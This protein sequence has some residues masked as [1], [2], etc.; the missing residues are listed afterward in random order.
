MAFWDYKKSSA[1]TIV[2]DDDVDLIC[3][4]NTQ[5]RNVYT[6]GAVGRCLSKQLASGRPLSAPCRKL[7]SVAAPKDIRSYLQVCTRRL[8]FFP[9]NF[10]SPLPT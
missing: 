10:V 8:P 1:L 7:V 5:K 2:C 4:A 9:A 3:P 6:I